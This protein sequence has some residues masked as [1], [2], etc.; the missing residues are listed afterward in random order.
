MQS[1]QLAEASH[2]RQIKAE[3]EIAA[4]KLMFHLRRSQVLFFDSYKTI[5]KIPDQSGKGTHDT[6]NLQMLDC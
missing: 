5:S 2:L 4:C 6:G 1:T 3:H